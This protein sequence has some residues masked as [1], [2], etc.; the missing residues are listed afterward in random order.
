M[1]KI[2]D[3]DEFLRE[4]RK[5]TKIAVRESIRPAVQQYAW[6]GLSSTGYLTEKE[7]TWLHTNF[8]NEYELNETFLGKL[9]DKIKT[10]AQS[11]SE[12][13]R[14]IYAKVSKVYHSAS[15]LTKY[16]VNL[17]QQNFDSLLGYFK[18]KFEPAKKAFLADI[19]TGKADM[20][21]IGTNIGEEV[22]QLKET[23]MWW[24]KQFQQMYT[25][26]VEKIY[27]KHLLKEA[28]DHDASIME[29]FI[30]FNVEKLNEE[31]ESADDNSIFKI[32]GKIA[33]DVE[34]IPPFNLLAGINELA[35]DATSA[36][37]TKFSSVTKKMGGP[38]VYKFV[39]IAL[40]VGFFTEYQ[41]KHIAI[42]GIEHVL[43]AQALLK[44]LPAIRHVIIGIEY[45]ALCLVIIETIKEAKKIGETVKA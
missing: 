18:K 9:R 34:K 29:K 1:S 4:S 37:L 15:A 5:V 44:F 20:K 2:L 14:S 22:N 32:V 36:A 12:L 39:G 38:G 45:T 21:K 10:A 13:G 25:R 3:F 19:R 23:V 17:F 24:L 40:V 33:H 6:H 31:D 16:L 41:V 43:S 11:G 26:S 8:P 28:V 42:E 7:I 35:K 27:S 30:N